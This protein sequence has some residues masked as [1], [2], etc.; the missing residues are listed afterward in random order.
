MMRQTAPAAS[1]SGAVVLDT[2]AAVVGSVP[3]ADDVEILIV[4]QITGTQAAATYRARIE[5]VP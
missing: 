5:V 3:L 2:F 4:T 1:A